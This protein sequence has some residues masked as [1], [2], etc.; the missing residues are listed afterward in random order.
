MGPSINIIRIFSQFLDPP[1]PLPHVA[2]CTHLTE[3]P[4]P[5]PPFLLRTYSQALVTPPPSTSLFLMQG[6]CKP[7]TYLSIT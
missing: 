1:P 3:P 2:L 7:I 6:S 5:P 4:P